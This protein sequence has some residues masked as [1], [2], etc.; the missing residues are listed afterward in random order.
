MN[1]LYNTREYNINNINIFYNITFNK[2]NKK[3]ILKSGL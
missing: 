3:G 2:G 1:K